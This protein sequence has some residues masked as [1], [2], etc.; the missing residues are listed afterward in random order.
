MSERPSRQ[1]R[2]TPTRQYAEENEYEKQGRPPQKTKM[3][4]AI[5]LLLSIT[6]IITGI[7]QFRTGT[8]MN[9][10]P[11]K[12]KIAEL[13]TEA[14][15]SMTRENQPSAQCGLYYFYHVG[16]VGGT[17]V[18]TWM[19]LLQKDNPR[20]ITSYFDFW[21][22]ETYGDYD[23]RVELNEI[24][25]AIYSGKMT[26]GDKTW[27][28]VHHHHGSPGLRYMMPSL[29]DWRTNLRS[30]GC[31]LI[32]TTVLREPFSR[33]RSI[34]RYKDDIHREDFEAF[35]ESGQ[36]NRE[37]G[38]VNYLLFNK[39]M[40]HE[41]SAYSSEYFPGGPKQD[42]VTTGAID[43]VV[44]YLKEFDIV[45]QTTKLD[46]FIALSEKVTGWS[47]LKH[48]EDIKGKTLKDNKS[49]PPKF[50]IT[51]EMQTFMAPYLQ[52]DLSLW[53]RVIGEA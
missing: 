34:V 14:S 32:L 22:K 15:V 51:A 50:N 42:E 44:D 12:V 23:W 10:G 43:E 39:D 31:D 24:E 38:V 4:P 46:S 21:H 2:A 33:A 27:L 28:S 47:E 9:E 11:G 49:D 5:L 25:D 48:M 6:V 8:S 26:V 19:W 29:R 7:L 36:N 53:K 16:K 45:G 37:E 18:K 3:A 17:S 30:Q 35:F 1:K 52:S 40:V 20:N 41:P 13:R